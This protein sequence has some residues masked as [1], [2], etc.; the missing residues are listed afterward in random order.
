MITW[1]WTIIY[2]PMEINFACL[3]AWLTRNCSI[4]ARTQTTFAHGDY[5]I[6][7]PSY[8]QAALDWT[9]RKTESLELAAR[10]WIRTNVQTVISTYLSTWWYWSNVF[11]QAEWTHAA[12][13]QLYQPVCHLTWSLVGGYWQ[14]TKAIIDWTCITAKHVISD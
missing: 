8:C 5:K 6:K 4:S 1:K 7:S 14:K 3:L 9:Q 2:K 13:A 11:Y 12:W 10:R